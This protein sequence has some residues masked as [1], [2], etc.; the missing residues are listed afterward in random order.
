MIQPKQPS[1][2]QNNI[3]IPYGVYDDLI[4]NVDTSVYDQQGFVT[5][6]RRTE[7]KT[8]LFF[9]VFSPDLICGLAIVDAGMVATAFSYFYSLKD[10]V[11]E[12]D[13]MTIP[14]GFSSDFNPNLYS[15]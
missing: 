2:I 14:L 9:G 1:L 13:K 10:G 8:W 12:E 5:K 15:E 7:R 4:A 3:H 11:F 6:K